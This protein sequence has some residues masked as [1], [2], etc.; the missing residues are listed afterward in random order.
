MDALP[1]CKGKHRAVRR[2]P[3]SAH[4][5]WFR[6]RVARRRVAKLRRAHTLCGSLMPAR[7]RAHHA[8]TGDRRQYGRGQ[9][10]DSRTHRAGP[11][12]GGRHIAATHTRLACKYW[13][14]VRGRARACVRAFNVKWVS[15]QRRRRRRSVTWGYWAQETDA[16]GTLTGAVH[17]SQIHTVQ[18]CATAAAISEL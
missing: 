4:Y 11:T 2:T 18:S 10:K 1:Q 5:Y 6:L 15:G 13:R 7:A 16:G 12:A 9:S 8:N 17:K 3:Q 14:M